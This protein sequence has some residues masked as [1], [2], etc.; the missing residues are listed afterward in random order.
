MM[1][2]GA[3]SPIE[4]ARANL[5]ERI[6]DFLAGR[7][8]LSRLMSNPNLQIS[9]Q[10]N[11]LYAV[12]VQLESQLQNDITPKLQALQGGSWTFSDI[13]QLIGFTSSVV[14]QIN[15]VNRLDSQAGGQSTAPFLSMQTM[16]IGGFILVTLGIMSGVLLG[17]KQST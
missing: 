2:L 14:S 9:G 11:G 17:R 10:A 1:A 12:Q 4:S 13:A 5:Q 3:L 6:A 7:A 15:S 8:R 16:A